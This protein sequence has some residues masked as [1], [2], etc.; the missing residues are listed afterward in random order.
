MIRWLRRK[1]GLIDGGSEKWIAVPFQTHSR[2]T[3]KENGEWESFPVGRTL[4]TSSHDARSR[5]LER[6][7]FQ[8]W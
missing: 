2:M 6:I 3:L 5:H 7:R 1:S 8:D 4:R